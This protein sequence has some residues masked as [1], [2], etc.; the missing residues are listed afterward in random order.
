MDR[1]AQY[2]EQELIDNDS[3]FINIGKKTFKCK[4]LT[5]WASGKITKLILKGELMLS[6]D[7]QQT[8]VSFNKNRQLAP[9]CLSLAILG[10]W[11]KIKL[12][13]PIFWRWLNYNFTQDQYTK[14]INKVL[15]F[16]DV[17]FFFLNM[18]SLQ[19]LV[20]VEQKMTNQTTKSIIQSQK[21]D[22]P[23]T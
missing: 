16:S 3:I 18:A 4:R 12:F 14:A 5:N 9:K 6:D 13:H 1:K 11:W 21:S 15:D 20:E 7:K 23:T 10:S 19:G 22:Q 8:L 2:L 17:K